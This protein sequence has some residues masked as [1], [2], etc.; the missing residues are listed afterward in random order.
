M[1]SRSRKKVIIAGAAGRDFHNFNIVFRDNP[2]YEVVCFTATQI[3]SIE[4]RRYPPELSGELYPDGIP[5]YP[6]EKLPELIKENNV[7]MVVLAYSDLSYSY[8]MERSAIVNAAGADF[9]LMGP[10]STMLKSKKPVIAVT[11]VR[12]G[13]GKSQISRKIFEILSEKGLKVVSIRHPMPYNRDLTTQV[14]QRFSSYDD[15]D[16]YDCTIEEREEYE[17]YIDMGGVVY[18]GV[19]YQK[20]LENAENEADIIIWDGGNNDFP[21][22]KPDLW[23]TVAD[24]HRPGHEISYYPG[25]VNFRSAHVIII[26]KANTAKR[27]NIEKIKENAKKINPNAKIIEG[28][29]D[30]IVEKPEKIKGK[31]VLVIE[32]GPTTTHGGVGYGAGYIASVENGAKEIIDPRPFAVGSIVE[33]FKKYAHLSK[34]LPAMGYGKEQIKE[35]EETINRCDADVVVSGTPIDLNRILNVNKP[36]VRVRYGVGK[37]TEKELR[38][39]LDEFLS[40]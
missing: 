29:S 1:M 21:F 11:A 15:L 36:I 7:D 6:E 4:N 19:D 26:N 13:C 33:T 8:V 20:I 10:K 22:I 30:I 23:I 16:R 27:E 5:I 24:P 14:M 17:P 12:T 38:H 39:I 25:E 35:L 18:A 2:D 40:S 28:I 37:E 3:P 9:V 32:D 34:V 31:R